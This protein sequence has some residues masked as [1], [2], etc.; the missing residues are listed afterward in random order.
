MEVVA[1]V[2]VVFGERENVAVDDD[3]D[4]DDVEVRERER[5]GGGGGCGGVMAV[6]LRKEREAGGVVGL[7]RGWWWWW[8]WGMEW[9][10]FVAIRRETE[11]ETERQI[12]SVAEKCE[13]G[14]ERS[15]RR[16]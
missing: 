12:G 14:K 8:V 4:D 1:V 15:L 3:D 16:K 11:R 5:E 9:R 6:G 13:V 2:E 7:R 10:L